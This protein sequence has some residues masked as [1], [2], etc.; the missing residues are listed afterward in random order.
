MQ[1]ACWSQNAS[2]VFPWSL[3]IGAREDSLT[4]DVDVLLQ[5]LRG[6]IVQPP[7]TLVTNKTL[8][9]GNRPGRKRASR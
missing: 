4:A 9:S 1:Q 5:S 2:F 7:E 3:N 8:F 6:S